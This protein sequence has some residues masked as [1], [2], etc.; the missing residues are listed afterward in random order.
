MPSVIGTATSLL[1]S[2]LGGDENFGKVLGNYA[3]KF[4]DI[5]WK[6]QDFTHW[7]WFPSWLGLAVDGFSGGGGA[8]NKIMKRLLHNM[9]NSPDFQKYLSLISMSLLRETFD[10]FQ[11][12]NG[13]FFGQFIGKLITSLSAVICFSLP[14]S[15]WLNALYIWKKN[16]RKKK[17]KVHNAVNVNYWGL[18][19]N[20][21]VDRT[22]VLS[23]RW[24][25]AQTHRK[26]NCVRL[27]KN[28]L[29]IA[30]AVFIILITCMPKNETTQTKINKSLKGYGA[31]TQRLH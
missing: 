3:G 25:F 26:S 1:S 15:W 31:F 16:E 22:S 13:Q 19:S 11:I 20:D 6:N 18:W 27:T 28:I 10:F 4:V 21:N 24:H 14:L 30:L 9:I 17:L 2:L 29:I 12:N 7:L 5:F 8:V 23:T